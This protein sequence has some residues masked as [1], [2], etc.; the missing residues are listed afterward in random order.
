MFHMPNAVT[1]GDSIVHFRRSDVIVAG[2]I[3][4]TTRYP[5]FDVKNGG[6]LN[7]EIE[8]L[9]YILTKTVYEHD[10]DGGT[11][12]IP[13]HGYLTNEF[14]VSEYRNMLVIIRDRI[15]A[16]INKGATL[17]Q[18]R[19]ARVTADYDERYGANTGSW[20]TDM[21]I[22]AVYTSLKQVKN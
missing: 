21:F 18:V 4:T 22:E 17:E 2:D 10:E 16:M 6:S 14:E 12:I 7:G 5:F 1:D 8:A 20:T 13:G 9:N 19:A 3:F 15:Q 11:V